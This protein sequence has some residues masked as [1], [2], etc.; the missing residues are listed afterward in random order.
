MSALVDQS[1]IWAVALPCFPWDGSYP[2]LPDMNHVD[3]NA[4]QWQK[5]A[6]DA[7]CRPPFLL[8]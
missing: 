2:L 4:P 8:Y 1:L 3:V 5:Q 7:K 6:H